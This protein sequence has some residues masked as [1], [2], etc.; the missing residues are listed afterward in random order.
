MTDSLEDRLYDYL[1]GGVPNQ[2]GLTLKHLRRA[3][4]EEQD[5]K[6]LISLERHPHVLGRGSKGRPSSMFVIERNVY[7]FDGT[8]LKIGSKNRSRIQYDV[9]LLA[10]EE[11]EFLDYCGWFEDYDLGDKP[12]TLAEVGAL[13]KDNCVDSD[14]LM[15][16]DA[17][18]TSEEWNAI[19]GQ[20]LEILAHDC[21]EQLVERWTDEQD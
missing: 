21:L 15:F 17:G 3:D 7:I 12:P 4:V 13:L 5:G 6:L 9:D 1:S 10:D 16:L 2:Y 11:R 20:V 14:K 8:E 18:G 19:N